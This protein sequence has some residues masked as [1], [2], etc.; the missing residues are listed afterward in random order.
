MYTGGKMTKKIYA[1]TKN[2]RLTQRKRIIKSAPV[3]T[4]RPVAVEYIGG[5]N[6]LVTF[7]NGERKV[8]NC[9]DIPNS[10]R[11]CDKPLQDINVF[12]NAFVNDLT[13]A[14]NDNL[15][16]CPDGLYKGCVPYSK[17]LEGQTQHS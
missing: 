13:V 15:E 5:W 10:N 4:P 3:F 11:E 17:W 7:N 1:K 14:W 12:K 6:L 2:S 9:D 8:C 16:V